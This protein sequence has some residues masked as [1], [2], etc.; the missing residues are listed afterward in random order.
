MTR[1]TSYSLGQTGSPRLKLKTL[2]VYPVYE[3]MTKDP[4]NLILFS[5]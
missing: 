5:K 1:H 4:E 2:T 3:F